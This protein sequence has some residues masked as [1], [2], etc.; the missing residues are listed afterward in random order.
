AATVFR[1]VLVVSQFAISIVLIAGTLVAFD[2]LDYMRNARL[3]FDKEQVVLLNLQLSPIPQQYDQVRERLLQHSGV[4]NVSVSEDVPGSKYQTFTLR[5]EGADEQR[6]FQRM[7]V[8]EDFVETMG[9]EMAAGRS[10]A[11]REYPTDENRAL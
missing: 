2:Q 1:K 10:Y 4:V 5:P 6:Q 9:M 8:M 3:G 11:P 7:M